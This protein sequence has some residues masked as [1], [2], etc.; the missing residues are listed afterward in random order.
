MSATTLKLKRLYGLK[1]DVK[2]NIQYVDEMNVIYPCGF[3]IISYEIEKKEQT[4]IPLSVQGR[5]S[6][7]DI[8]ALAISP[9]RGPGSRAKL[10]AVA[11]RGTA[12]SKPSVSVFDLAHPCKRRGTRSC[13]CVCL[14]LLVDGGCRTR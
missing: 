5:P 1:G 14:L 12:N 8:S 3:N 4:F 11:E 9:A 13:I 10:M 6:S 2:G 7:G